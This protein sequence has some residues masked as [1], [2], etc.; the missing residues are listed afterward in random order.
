MVIGTCGVYVAAPLA[1]PLV[2]AL[3]GPASAEGRRPES[4]GALALKPV[5]SRVPEVVKPPVKPA[6]QELRAADAPAPREAPQQVVRPDE[7]QP[8]AL[9]GIF[10]AQRGDKPGWGVTHQRASYYTLEGARV[11]GVA[12]GVILEYRNAHTSSK[13]GMV[14]CVI[15]ENG[16]PSAPLLVSTKDVFLFTGTFRKLSERQIKDVQAYYALSGKIASRKTE[17]LQAAAAKNPHFAVYNAAH[18]ALMAHIESAKELAG[19]RDR[20]TELEKTQLEDRLREMKI[21][22]TRLRT[23]YDAQL[24]KFRTWKQEHASEIAKPENDPD[25]KKWMQEMAALRPRIPGLAY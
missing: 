24:L 20:A 1:R 23:E 21:A 3:K 22:E 6:A 19:K 7:E 17:L 25:V 11:G 10:L 4:Q 2:A 16:S 5:P 8:P 13:G 14:E 15:Y 12:G 18:T 9:N